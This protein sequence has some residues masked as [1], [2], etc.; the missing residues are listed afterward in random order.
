MAFSNEIEF[1]LFSLTDFFTLKPV[2][3]IIITYI[4]NVAKLILQLTIG[5][6]IILVFFYRDLVNFIS[7][8]WAK[9]L[10]RYEFYRQVINF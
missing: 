6:K 9:H 10:G 5:K 1:D 4:M 8:N 3:H 7:I 2:M